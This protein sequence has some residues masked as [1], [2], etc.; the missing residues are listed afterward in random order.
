MQ[1][2]PYSAPQTS[3]DEL[4]DSPRRP[5]SVKLAAAFIVGNLLAG[6]SKFLFIDTPLTGVMMGI[7]FALVFGFT[8]LLIAAV[9]SR[10]NW[11]RW[12]VA[13]LLGA[14]LS[15]FPFAIA[16]ASTPTLRIILVAQ[17]AFQLAALV[18]MF[19]PPSVRWYR[20]NNSFK[21]NPQ[22]GGA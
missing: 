5:T 20:S 8:A 16:H 12:V 22:Q 21:P 3:G 4:L 13:G 10:L 18:L 9:L 11:A 17:A 6:H 14:S 19:L 2:N 15:F 1:E 7:A